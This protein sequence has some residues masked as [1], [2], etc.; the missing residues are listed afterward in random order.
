MVDTGDLSSQV[1]LLLSEEEWVCDDVTLEA[2]SE[3]DFDRSG[4][5]E[6]LWLQIWKHGPVSEGGTSDPISFLVNASALGLHLSRCWIFL[7]VWGVW[8]FTLE[9]T[10]G[11]IVVFL[12]TSDFTKESNILRTSILGLKLYE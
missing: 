11:D 9:I 4:G 12:G 1:M 10:F 7:V 8:I 6:I 2:T 3:E 5:Y